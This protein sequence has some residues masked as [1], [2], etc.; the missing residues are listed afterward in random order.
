MATK[1]AKKKAPA[2]KVRERDRNNPAH[3]QDFDRLLDDAIGVK[4][5]PAG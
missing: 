2:K 3:K 5:K 4:R 1:K